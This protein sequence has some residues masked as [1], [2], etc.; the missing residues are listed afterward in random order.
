MSGVT[1]EL[2]GASFEGKG[3]GISV[4]RAL[5][6]VL[7]AIVIILVLLLWQERLIRDY[8]RAEALSSKEESVRIKKLFLASRDENQ[9]LRREI[10]VR[11]GLMVS[12]RKAV[13]GNE[14]TGVIL[15]RE[16]DQRREEIS[17]LRAVIAGL[18]AEND[19]IGTA[20]RLTVEE[21]D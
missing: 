5:I 3:W 14:F 15:R 11:R 10:A 13:E 16:L 8:W 17:E 9:G 20:C 6:S 7:S 18:Y 1:K 12:W 21:E 2:D 4:S 19:A